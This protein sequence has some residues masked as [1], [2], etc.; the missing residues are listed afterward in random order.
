M[1]DICRNV[2]KRLSMVQSNHEVPGVDE[3]YIA[4]EDNKPNAISSLKRY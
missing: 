1:T 4:V 2:L 3:S